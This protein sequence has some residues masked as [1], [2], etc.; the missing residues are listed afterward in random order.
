MVRKPGATANKTSIHQRLPTRP[1]WKDWH[2]VTVLNHTPTKSAFLLQPEVNPRRSLY[3]F[4]M[5]H[6]VLHKLNELNPYDGFG[7]FNNAFRRLLLEGTSRMIVGDS[8]T[9]T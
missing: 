2:A 7:Q 5:E 4:G 1:Q 9:T 3:P 6:S 8:V